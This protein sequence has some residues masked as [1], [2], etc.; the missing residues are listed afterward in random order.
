[1]PQASHI[2][3]LKER[4]GGDSQEE[5]ILIPYQLSSRT[6]QSS[7]Q[8]HAWAAPQVRAADRLPPQR[9]CIA[10]TKIRE[11]LSSRTL[12]KA[13]AAAN[14]SENSSTIYPL[15]SF[16]HIPQGALSCFP[17]QAAVCR[18]TYDPRG[19]AR[20]RIFDSTARCFAPGTP[21]SLRLTGGRAPPGPAPRRPAGM[22][23]GK[24][25]RKETARGSAQ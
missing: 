14:F 15:P 24:K 3:Q 7:Q 19:G 16:L 12:V 8:T 6:G 25:P 18:A 17:R 11:H 23:K 5:R 4:N 2:I 22:A 21:V 1:M 13:P 20:R 9:R 10:Y